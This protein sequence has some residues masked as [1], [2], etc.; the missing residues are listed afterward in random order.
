MN[1]TW[2]PDIWMVLL[3]RWP[4]LN[5]PHADTVNHRARTTITNQSPALPLFL[6]LPKCHTWPLPWPAII[7][8]MNQRHWNRST[9]RQGLMST[10][11]CLPI[12]SFY[13]LSLSLPPSCGLSIFLSPLLY[14]SV[15][16]VAWSVLSR[17]LKHQRIR[18]CP[19]YTPFTSVIL[20]IAGQHLWTCMHSHPLSSAL[21]PTTDRW[22]YSF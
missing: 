18:N 16:R 13:S 3:F 8:R 6:P 15:A 2:Q 11:H 14:L 7:P 12:F 17:G 21:H 10:W 5:G 4:L 1:R 20:Y 22:L 9:E 19:G